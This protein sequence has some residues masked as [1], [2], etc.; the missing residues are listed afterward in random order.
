MLALQRSLFVH[1]WWN[2]TF[3]QQESIKLTKSD[4]EDI[5]NAIIVSSKILSSTTVFKIDNSFKYFLSSNSAY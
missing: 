1:R 4:I 2:I 5:Y 3:I